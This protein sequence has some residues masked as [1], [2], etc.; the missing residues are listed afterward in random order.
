MEGDLLIGHLRAQCQ[1]LRE[2]QQRFRQDR[3]CQTGCH[4]IDGGEAFA[5]GTD[6]LNV[7][8]RLETVGDI[9]IQ[10]DECAGGIDI[11]PEIIGGFDGAI[12]AVPLLDPERHDIGTCLKRAWWNGDREAAFRIGRCYALFLQRHIVDRDF[13]A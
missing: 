11:G 3:V 2:F 1:R 7:F 9:R 10:R 4:D 5:A 6:R 13:K 8:D 12:R